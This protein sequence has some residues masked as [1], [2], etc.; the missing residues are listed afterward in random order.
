MNSL[1]LPNPHYQPFGPQTAKLHWSHWLFFGNSH[2]VYGPTAVLYSGSKAPNPRIDLLS[3]IELQYALW[4]SCYLSLS[5]IQFW[6]WQLTKQGRTRPP[7]GQKIRALATTASTKDF[8]YVCAVVHRCRLIMS[9]GASPFPSSC[10]LSY[11]PSPLFCPL[12]FSAA[13]WPLLAI[14]INPQLWIHFFGLVNSIY[15]ETCKWNQSW[16]ILKCNA[17][18]LWAIIFCHWKAQ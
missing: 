15:Y 16:S 3:R 17:I 9:I 2:T 13:K 6:F 1:S 10:S 7:W 18:R 8:V 11:A 12:P 4:H 5:A 14:S